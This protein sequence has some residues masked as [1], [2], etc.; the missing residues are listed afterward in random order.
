MKSFFNTKTISYLTLVGVIITAIATSLTGY[1]AFQKWMFEISPEGKL[2]Y[3]GALVKESIHSRFVPAIQI[4]FRVKNQAMFPIEFDVQE[5]RTE[6]MNLHPSKKTLEKKNLT[7]P[8]GNVGL[9]YDNTIELRNI[10]TSN[11]RL[12]GF[13]YVRFKY[14]H[15]GNL[16]YELE[17]KNQIW[18][19]FDELGKLQTYEYFDM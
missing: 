9:F 11:K 14:G 17:F 12:S 6:L 2:S 3:G 19:T 7:V 10:Q 1:V 13:L 16:I 8:I 5:I 4:G 18:I 15:P